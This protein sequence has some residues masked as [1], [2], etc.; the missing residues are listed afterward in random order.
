M[1]KLISLL[2]AI[3]VVSACSLSAFASEFTINGSETNK[4]TATDAAAQTTYEKGE[5]G[6]YTVDLS[7]VAGTQDQTT[8]LAVK[9]NNIAVG[10]I[11][12]I[13]QSADKTFSFDLKDNLTEQVNVLAGGSKISPTLVGN[14]KPAQTQTGYTISGAVVDTAVSEVDFDG[15]VEELG[16]EEVNA[17]KTGWA[18]TVYLV[19]DDDSHTQAVNY[20]TNY[21]AQSNDLHVETVA[22]TTADLS[23]GA[24][25]FK[26]ISAGKYTLIFERAG[27]LPLMTYVT[28][29][30][31]NVNVAS[32][33]MLL[34]DFDTEGSRDGCC[35]GT[36]INIITSNYDAAYGDVNYDTKFDIDAT[37]GLDGGDINI[38]VTNYDFTPANY[39]EDAIDD[40]LGLLE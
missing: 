8:I 35:D 4:L 3:S 2:A 5:N 33:T 39:A 14:M 32:K 28:V 7:S 36:D 40:A 26:D 38:I 20:L 9:G 12:Y 19:A 15:L 18:T 16:E 24:Y 29:T 27:A 13:G 11:Q 1:K 23:T 21:Y 31:S 30:D 22:I 37:F 6:L 25:S 34:G 17:F 10:S